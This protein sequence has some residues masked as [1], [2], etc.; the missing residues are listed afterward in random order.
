MPYAR[1]ILCSEL[2]LSCSESGGDNYLW[3]DSIS[4]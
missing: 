3:Y 4:Y 2:G 1:K